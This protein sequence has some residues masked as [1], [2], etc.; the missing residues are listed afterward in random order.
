[1]STSAD[2]GRKFVRVGPR[3]DQTVGRPRSEQLRWR[4]LQDHRH[5]KETCA[6]T[7]AQSL[8]QVAQARA[9]VADEPFNPS[10]VLQNFKLGGAKDDE[11]IGGAW[12]RMP[13]VVC[14]RSDAKS[15]G[16]ACRSEFGVLDVFGKTSSSRGP[17]ER[18]RRGLLKTIPVFTTTSLQTAILTNSSGTSMFGLLAITLCN[19]MISESNPR[20][21]NDEH[22]EIAAPWSDLGEHLPSLQFDI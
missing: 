15:C 11:D 4:P 10:K 17:L 19:V 18:S 1:M 20:P 12:A 6:A 2:I 14:V 22:T 21:F 13:K 7:D 8:L 5:Q 16:F 3:F 9:A